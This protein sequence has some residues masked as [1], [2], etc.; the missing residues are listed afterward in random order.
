[1]GPST[2][3]AASPKSSSSIGLSSEVK[4]S[5]VD[6]INS[7]CA[8]SWGDLA[9]V[10]DGIS[11]DEESEAPSDRDEDSINHDLRHCIDVGMSDTDIDS[12]KIIMKF[13]ES[14]IMCMQLSH[15]TLWKD[16]RV[17]TPSA[18]P[19]STLIT[20]LEA[21]NISHHPKKVKSSNPLARTEE[22]DK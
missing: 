10:F 13:F 7:N 3:V 20:L 8:S 22:T 12:K 16:P 21:A 9:E 6:D 18:T 17:S 11:D 1:L 5:I 2:T 14:V 15:V 19:S 4:S